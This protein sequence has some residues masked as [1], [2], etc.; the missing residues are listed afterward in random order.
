VGRL[1]RGERPRWKPQ[2]VGILEGADLTRVLE[3]SCAYRP[4]FELLAY[5][6]LRIGEALG[7]RWGDVDFDAGLLR[8]CQQLSRDRTPKRLKT[9]AGKREVVLAGPLAATLRARWNVAAHRESR[10]LV[11]CTAGGRGLNYR[12]VGEAFRAAVHESGVT[13]RGRLSLHSLRHS[14]ASLLIAEGLNVVFVSRQL[15]HAK[16]TTTLGVYAH[17]Y[18]QADHAT[19]ARAALQASYEAMTARQES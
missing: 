19:A 1:E 15:G 4:V 3:H 2:P 7:L 10:D 6:G 5:T 11:F 9:D 14:F 16:A 17:L 8:V 18:A 13:G 12:H